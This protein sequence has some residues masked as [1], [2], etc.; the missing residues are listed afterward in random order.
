MRHRETEKQR[1]TDRQTDRQADRQ[2]ERDRD[3][4]ADRQTEGQ[5][6]TQTDTETHRQTQR[7][8]DRHKHT[9]RNS[10]R[11][12]TFRH[13]YTVRDRVTEKEDRLQLLFINPVT[14]MVPLAWK[15]PIRLRH[16]ILKPFCILFRISMRKVFIKTQY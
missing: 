9:Q 11:I 1:E 5:R 16:L 6:H 10:S 14:A 15:R 8:T 13:A 3:R 4:Q 7:Q 2:T 12:L